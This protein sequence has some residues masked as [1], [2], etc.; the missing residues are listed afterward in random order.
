MTGAASSTGSA[1][2]GR[3][4][5]ATRLL[6]APLAL[7]AGLAL[8]A[9]GG[10]GGG[11][12][13][14]VPTGT[15]GLH[16]L[17]GGARTDTIG[18]RPTERLQVVLRDASGRATAGALV[19]FTALSSGVSLIDPSATAPTT[20]SVSRTTSAEGI[21]E[22]SVA[23]GDVPGD[24]KVSIAV[25]GLSDT[26][27]YTVQAGAP[28]S[29]SLAPADTIITVGTPLTLRTAQRDRVGNTTQGAVTFSAI[30]V[31]SQLTS[32]GVIAASAAMRGTIVASI[33]SGGKT[34][35]D[36]SLVSVVPAATIA[37]RIGTRLVVMKLDGTGARDVPFPLTRYNSVHWT[38]DGQSLI[39]LGTT[40]GGF[41]ESLFRIDLAGVATRL[42]TDPPPDDFNEPWPGVIRSIEPSRDGKSVY[43]G[44]NNCN[45]NE[46]LY[47]VDLATGGL[48]RISPTAELSA[49]ATAYCE[50]THRQASTNADGSV[51]IYVAS[52]GLRRVDV[53]TGAVTTLALSGDVPAY[54]PTEPRIATVVNG[55]IMIAG[56]DGSA[57]RAVTGAGQIA[58]FT[59][60]WSPDGRW[61]IASDGNFTPVIVELATGLTIPLSYLDGSSNISLPDWRPAP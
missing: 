38:P 55:A 57:S 8:G 53:V 44:A 24:A 34:L 9:C 48:Q 47:R 41:G 3:S 28:A 26:A 29:F 17:S 54:S 52:N 1:G 43:F 36:T 18:A 11:T 6:R 58:P 15:P 37:V 14:I 13:P 4:P 21:T 2:S 60:A 22:V 51:L 40:T 32:T 12:E 7:A 30:G 35:V 42:Y 49:S 19:V 23:F 45:Q 16:I 25:A 33:A 31:G 27:R 46:L 39:A 59:M 56:E 50:V 10:G 20:A 5:S 61:L